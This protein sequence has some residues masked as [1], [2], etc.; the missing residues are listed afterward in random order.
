M[1]T[2][3]ELAALVGGKVVGDEQLEV[4][5]VAPLNAARP[6][7]ITFVASPKH[8][9]GLRGTQASAVILFPGADAGPL[10]AIVCDN[11]YLAFAKVLTHLQ[12]RRPATRGVLPGARVAESAQLGADVTIHPG[13]VVGERVRIG[14]GTILYPQV[15][16]YDDVVIGDDCTLHAGVIVREGCRIGRRVILQPAAVIGSDGFGFAPDGEHYFKIPQVGIVEIEDD[17]EIGSATCVDRAALGVTR[18]RRGAKIDNLVQIAH[19]VVV[20]EDTVIVSQVGIAGSTEIGR[21][22]TFGGQSGTVGHLKIGDHVTVGG[23]GAVTGHVPSNKVISGTPAIDHQ[24]WLKA[25][26]VFAKLPE[27]RR[28]I[29]RLKRQLD[30]L[31]DKIKES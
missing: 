15:V 8:L 30:E 21:H 19:N 9:G 16:L 2:L 27:M 14:A 25:S 26:M 3:K 10:P 29:S 24:D 23:R 12:V 1:A 4:I 7:D 20:G 6:G 31:T 28:E 5:R 13:C 18:I 11:P 17:V 22:C